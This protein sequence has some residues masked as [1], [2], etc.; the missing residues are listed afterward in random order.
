M[1]IDHKTGQKLLKAAMR[2]R[3]A[4]GKYDVFA[5]AENGELQ[6]VTVRWKSYTSRGVDIESG[7]DNELSM[8]AAELPNGVAR[9]AAYYLGSFRVDRTEREDT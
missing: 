8:N 2:E 9:H 6:T 5:W 4:P 1:K 7:A 3:L